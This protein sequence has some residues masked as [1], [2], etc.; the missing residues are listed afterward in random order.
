MML[1]DCSTTIRETP[2]INI[3]SL[4]VGTCEILNIDLETAGDP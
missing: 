2:L 1:M 4:H 3:P